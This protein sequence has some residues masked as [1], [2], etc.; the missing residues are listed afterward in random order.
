MLR[1]SDIA[2]RSVTVSEDGICEPLIFKTSQLK[3]CEDGSCTIILHGIKNDY[4]REGFEVVV[5][6][7]ENGRVDPVK[8]LKCYVE[9]TRY[10]RPEECPVFLSLKKPYGAISSKT[11][12]RILEKAI[13]CA[14]LKGQGYSAKCFHPTGATNTIDAGLNSD[15]VQAV[16]RWKSKE[17]FQNHYVHSRPVRSFTDRVFQQFELSD[18]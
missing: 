9:R 1:P 15:M 14:G 10:I 12:T 5:Q 13:I 16:G 11:V 7:T 18:Q 17:T 6:P 3:F 4:M 8:A 2:P